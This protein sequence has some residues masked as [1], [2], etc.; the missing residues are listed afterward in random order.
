[1]VVPTLIGERYQL[2]NP[3][4]IPP[5]PLPLLKGPV[6]LLCPE[7][8]IPM[9]YK[10]ALTDSWRIACPS[11]NYKNDHNWR[12]WRCD[13]LN[14]EIAL[15]NLGVAR[16]IISFESDWGPRVSPDGQVLEI[17][18]TPTPGI[19]HHPFLGRLEQSAG[20]PPTNTTD[21][22]STQSSRPPTTLQCKR[23]N[24]GQV[25]QNH[26]MAANKECPHQYCRG[27]HI[28][29]A[30]LFCICGLQHTDLCCLKCCIAY[31]S[32]ICR[33]HPRASGSGNVTAQHTNN[34]GLIDRSNA[35]LD[36]G[37]SRTK[38]SASAP[39]QWAQSANSLGR[40]VPKDFLAVIQKNR[41]EREAAAAQKNSSFIDET[42]L[43]TVQLWL[44][45]VEPKVITALFP[46]WPQARLD[47]SELLM[48]AVLDVLGQQ[49]N[50]ALS[51]WDK[52]ISA[53]H[54]T[55][56]SYP[57]RFR[58]GQ[59]TIIARL[60]TVT[61]PA[62]V[63]NNH[64]ESKKS[65]PNNPPPSAFLSKS[66]LPAVCNMPSSP[67]FSPDRSQVASTN[68]DERSP[69]PITKRRRLSSLPPTNSIVDFLTSLNGVGPS[70][71]E[72]S[73]KVGEVERQKDTSLKAGLTT[74]SSRSNTSASVASVAKV[75]KLKTGWPSPVLV[76]S[77]LAW[78][79]E[80]TPHNVKR[81][82][83]EHFGEEWELV[84]PTMY[85]YR[86]FVG[87]VGH[88]TMLDKYRTQPNAIVADARDFYLDIFNKVAC[89][90]KGKK[91]TGVLNK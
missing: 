76:S 15:I 52:K 1:M 86:Q 88:E 81:K 36:V 62:T 29:S 3:T 14:H 33:K 7:C 44:N 61:V 32:G 60:Q 59:R 12:T 41:I 4:R 53:W 21:S 38:A 91:E 5:L 67:H 50:Q 64:K 78:W 10:T 2:A 65:F 66:E 47:E 87:M 22:N 39:H 26:K 75:P 63:M 18:P 49:W 69:T 46:N 73:A 83:L 16:P 48:Q 42:K 19:H 57:Q 68:D 74:A 13:Q 37:S 71:L 84:L 89:V 85:R 90:V 25:S 70:S 82:W 30:V 11:Q 23:I 35:L 9:I 34:L 77:L 20:M 17:R 58:H 79:Q 28:I 27:V 8:S 54:D 31:G 56:V 6:G 51:F 72:A 40:R 45:D 24:E 80:T 43:V 55:L